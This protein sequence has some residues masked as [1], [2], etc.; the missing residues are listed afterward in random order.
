M[1]EGNLSLE[2]LLRLVRFKFERKAEKSLF[3]SVYFFIYLVFFFFVCAVVQNNFIIIRFGF[4][5]EQTKY[6]FRAVI[7]MGRDSKGLG[8]RV[9][10]ILTCCNLDFFCW[11]VFTRWCSFQR[12]V[13]SL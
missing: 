3:F 2:K 7:V 8:G 4:C 9:V 6:D 1:K 5:I 13:K 11:N 12:S 10:K